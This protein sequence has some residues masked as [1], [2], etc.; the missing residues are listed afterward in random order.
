MFQLIPKEMQ[1][2]DLFEQQTEKVVQAAGLLKDLV[3]HYDRIDE[4]VQ[5]I[6]Q[7][8]HDGDTLTHEIIERLNKTFVTPID[9][10]D[11]HALVANLDDVLDL[12]EA[13]ADK[14]TMYRID[15][16]S[17]EAVALAE[18]IV[19]M[20]AELDKMIRK[21]RDL[22]HA[23]ILTHCIEINSLENAG[24]RILRGAVAALFAGG[25][26]PVEVMKWKEIYEDLETATD[27][28]EDVANIV[29]G[30][31]LKHS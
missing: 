31:V 5:L 11:I 2:F 3:E 18:V 23:H 12:I 22:K 16:P 1:F 28:C 30:V 8:E 25:H 7:V 6:K 21:L 27:K 17:P 10:E 15:R 29:E 9:R 26:D 14:M 20:A 4:K 19:K 13:A 24:D